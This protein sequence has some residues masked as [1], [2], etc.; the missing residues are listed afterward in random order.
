MPTV[1]IDKLNGKIVENHTTKDAI[2]DAC[3]V[4]R[5]TFYRRLKNNALL[6]SDVQ[7]ICKA[8][9]LSDT[10]ALDIFMP[11]YSHHAT[12]GLSELV[13]RF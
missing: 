5:S 7:N 4:N 11:F 1:N 12:G 8:L 10:D 3:G 6:L 9:N 13:K 2:A